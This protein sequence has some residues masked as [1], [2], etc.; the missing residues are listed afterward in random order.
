MKLFEIINRPQIPTRYGG[1]WY[2][3]NTNTEYHV[4]T[5]HIEFLLNHPEI[6]G[7]DPKDLPQP[8]TEEYLRAKMLDY[9]DGEIFQD[10]YYGGWIRI[11]VYQGSSLDIS[12]TDRTA[13]KA[14]RV[15]VRMAEEYNVSTI[16]IDIIEKMDP[17]VSRF[18]STVFKWPSQ[19][20]EFINYIAS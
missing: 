13:K 5:T 18:N 17:S 16:T 12:T 6:F 2:N 19:R 20:R 15:L 4:D 1:F 8:G 11:R 9:P 7:F 14:L 10:A 3:V